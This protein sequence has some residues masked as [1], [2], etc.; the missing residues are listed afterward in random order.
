MM[1]RT[2]CPLESVT[3]SVTRLAPSG[4]VTWP[5]I[6][7]PPYCALSAVARIECPTSDAPVSICDDCSAVDR[8]RQ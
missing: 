2:T 4:T 1:C 8:R 5:L 3:V 6:D 7:P